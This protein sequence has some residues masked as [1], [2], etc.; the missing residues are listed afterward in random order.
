MEYLRDHWQGRHA[1]ARSFWLNLALPFILIAYGEAQIRPVPGTESTAEAATALLYLVIG[2]AVILPWQV[3]GFW[4]SSRRHL[5]E[6]GDLGA[7]TF[8]QG[9]AVAF[10]I[11][12]IVG[13]VTTLQH[14]LAPAA[15]REF[16]ETS[17]D[18]RLS[19]S[20]DETTV[21]IDGPIDVG[22]TR[23]LEALLDETPAITIIALK[24]NGG[25]VFEA[26]GVAKQIIDHGLDTQVTEH[27]RSACTIAFIAGKTRRL[28]NEGRLGFHSYRL[29]AVK[30]FVDPI[31]EQEK[32]KAF[33]L[34]Q[35]LD[36]AFVE[37]AFST[38]H[39]GMWHPSA[40][41]LLR[42]KVVHEVTK[43]P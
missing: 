26:R 34:A 16:A 5:E 30:S 6:R 8:A 36:L 4:R 15:T 33:F 22:L 3:V 21:I 38:P 32:D 25:R 40:D 2:Y 19:V 14:I 24:S 31:E 9:A 11:A 29:H 42:A 13:T 10:L 41:R 20:A 7:V 28:G 27:C 23:D 18:Y 12:A 43:D 35:G 17:P 1:L 39:E 37:Q